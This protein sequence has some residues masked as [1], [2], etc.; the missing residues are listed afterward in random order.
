M[1]VGEREQTV[2]K[3]CYTEQH[4]AMGVPGVKA[5]TARF[6]LGGTFGEPEGLQSKRNQGCEILG[7]SFVVVVRVA[8]L[9]AIDAWL[10]FAC[11][12]DADQ[13]AEF[14]GYHV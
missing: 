5:H 12:F 1:H 7:G 3:G 9:Q 14:V 4:V 10:E 6:I 13:V 8:G 11:V 2:V